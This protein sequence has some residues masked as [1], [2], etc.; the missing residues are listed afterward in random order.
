MSSTLISLLKADE[1]KRKAELEKPKLE[2]VPKTEQLP[3][4]EK[5]A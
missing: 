3:P 4:V 5:T 2:V 1:E